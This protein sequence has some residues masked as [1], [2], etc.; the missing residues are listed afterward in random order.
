MKT[1]NEFITEIMD[2]TRDMNDIQYCEFLE[3][4]ASALDDAASIKRSEIS[5]EL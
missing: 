5:H 1:T 3:E 2:A 4:I